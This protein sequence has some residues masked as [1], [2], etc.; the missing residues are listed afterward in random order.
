M[1]EGRDDRGDETRL[2]ADGEPRGPG[3][4][5]TDA[6]PGVGWAPAVPWAPVAPEPELGQLPHVT[7]GVGS[8][9]GRTLDTFLSRPMLFV[10]LAFPTP[11]L[12]AIRAILAGDP[13]TEGLGV[14]VALVEIVVGIAVTLSIILAAD[15]LRAGREPSYDALIRRALDRSIEGILSTIVNFLALF[16]ILFALAIVFV[17]IITVG[18]VAGVVLGAVA[19]IVASIVC[20]VVFIR[21]SL[22]QPAIA[23]DQR[24]PVQALNRSWQVTRGNALRIFGLFL[25]IGL[26][27]L[28]L[29]FGL[30][31]L[32]ASGANPIIVLLLTA[33]TS[34]VLAPLAAIGTSLAYGDLTG[35]PAADRA[36]AQP[37]RGRAALVGVI[38]GVGILASLAALP[39]IGPL[40]DQLSIAGVPAQD[41]GKILAG[42]I[43]NT[44]D[45]CR[46]GGVDSTFT[47][48][49]TIYIGGYFSKP[50][51]RGQSATVSVYVD[52]SLVHTLSVSN[53]LRA[54]G[55]YYEPDPLIGARAGTYRVVVAYAGETIA[56]GEFTIE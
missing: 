2:S 5:P 20:A 47:S 33:A 15:D 3:E 25:V 19:I 1:S 7:L 14:P 26:A 22:A 4:Q 50:V 42:A 36:A 34:L 12:A 31:I 53:S 45:R 16:G 48:T 9:F 23:L 24:G 30:W 32:F 54:V 40:I 41:R 38:L 28:P 49:D 13:R 56:D 39:Q 27:G 17:L 37:R 8:V 51:P 52:G 21:W 29:T 35:R 10:L 6:Q 18:G 46:P 55:C 43:E 44:I 11:I